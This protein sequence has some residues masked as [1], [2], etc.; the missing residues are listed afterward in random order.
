L[1]HEAGGEAV[2]IPTDVSKAL[3]VAA[4]IDKTVERYGR[5]D[6]AFNNAGIIDPSHSP[7]ITECSEGA[8]DQVIN[9]NL[10]GVWLCMKYQI[11]VLLQQGCGAIVNMSSIF[12][13]VGTNSGGV[14]SASKHAVIGLTKSVAKQYA[15]QGIRV[16]AICP[17]FVD[18]PLIEF[19]TND[20]N[21]RAALAALH[22]MGRL[23]TP[24]ES[25]EAVV[26]L[27]SEAASFVTGHALVA[28]GG[29]LS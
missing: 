12:G 14:Y 17:A 23:G 16:N 1:I 27:C 6:Y 19:I 25:A 5:L 24:Q 26:W 11:P 13:L 2:F 7:S 4:L 21:L 3:E 22:P 29:Y 10:K 20:P 8:W 15:C 28:D 9:I 18:T